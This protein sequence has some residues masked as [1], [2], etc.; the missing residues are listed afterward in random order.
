DE[1]VEE[2]KNLPVAPE[3]EMQRRFD[4]ICHRGLNKRKEASAAQEEDQDKDGTSA[5]AQAAAPQESQD[6]ARPQESDDADSQQAAAAK[7]SASAQGLI[8]RAERLARDKKSG[9]QQRLLSRLRESWKEAGRQQEISEEDRQRFSQALEQLEELLRE[10]SKRNQEILEEIRGHLGEV[11]R[12]LAQGELREART[13]FRRCSRRFK[14]LPGLTRKQRDSM[15]SRLKAVHAGVRELKDWHHWA[16]NQQRLRLIESMET[17]SE[18]DLDPEEL[19]KRI[20]AARNEWMRLEDSEKLPDD[21]PHY[22]SGPGLWRRFHAACNRAYE[23]C[24]AYFKER[25]QKR[26][27]KTAELEA[28]CQELEQMPDPTGDPPDWK[29]LDQLIRKG[30]R[31]LKQLNEI[32]PK[33]RGAMARR[34]RKALKKLDRKLKE[35]QKP[36]EEAKKKLIEAAKSQIEADD[37]GQATA[38]IRRLQ[39]EWKESGVTVRHREQALWK[40]FRAACNAVYERFK[41]QRKA[42]NK[43]QQAHNREL[44]EICKK[45]EDLCKLDDDKLVEA[46]N[47]FEEARQAWEKA[48]SRSP[49]LERRFVRACGRFAGRLK[50]ARRQEA[51]RRKREKAQERVTALREKA[52][53]CAQLESSDRLAGAALQAKLK[54]AES[55]WQELAELSKEDERHMRQRFERACQALREGRP[56]DWAETSEENLRQ[57]DLLCVRMEMLAGIDSPPESA[58]VRMRYQVSR[59]SSALVDREKPAN[60]QSEAREIQQALHLLG[61]LPDKQAEAIQKRFQQALDSFAQ[62]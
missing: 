52:A 3:E 12:H 43:A 14:G 19:N 47:E 24:K 51:V 28:V 48:E 27:A 36:Y 18:S 38:E 58:D 8:E 35:I 44:M 15:R 55:K 39:K 23:P 45:I 2:W 21:P 57:A 37:L 53:L 54:S 49:G 32:E 11:E 29:P 22:A 60:P 61:P 16:N 9:L 34:I 42:E 62:K 1:I 56:E 20:K 7:K 6:A 50:S 25:A 30:A 13:L 10:Q 59:L 4:A 17:L 40:E 31:S 46:E 41:D 33:K 5:T 26:E